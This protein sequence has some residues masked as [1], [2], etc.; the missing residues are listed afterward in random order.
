[1]EISDELLQEFKDRMHITHDIEDENLK[2]L[3][4][5]SVVDLISKCGP[6]RYVYS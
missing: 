5:F 3:L 1:M 2:R 4:S 6:F